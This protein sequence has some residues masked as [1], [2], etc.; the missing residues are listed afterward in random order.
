MMASISNSITTCSMKQ[1]CNEISKNDEDFV[2]YFVELC[3]YITP[4][5]EESTSL[6]VAIFHFISSLSLLLG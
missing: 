1:S 6:L 2:V 4:N 5:P 3:T